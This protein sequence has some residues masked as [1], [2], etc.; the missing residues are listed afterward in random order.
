MTASIN[1]DSEILIMKTYSDWPPFIT[2][3]QQNINLILP[4]VLDITV[5]SSPVVICHGLT[6]YNKNIKI[7]STIQH[8]AYG[9]LTDVLLTYI[10]I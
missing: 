9:I 6:I 8:S 5:T 4:D 3:S 10:I 7:T 2:E 1:V